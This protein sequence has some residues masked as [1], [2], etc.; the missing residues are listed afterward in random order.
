V[1]TV[2]RL[3]RV[4]DI[5][6]IAQIVSIVYMSMYS[7]VIDW[8]PAVVS[9]LQCEWSRERKGTGFFTDATFVVMR[10][11]ISLRRRIILRC[12]SK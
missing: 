7:Q 12:F 11:V 6:I 2:E 10:S 8:Q 3:L 4:M 1:L 9:W 5:R